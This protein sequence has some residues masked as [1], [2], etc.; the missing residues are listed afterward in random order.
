MRGCCQIYP[1]DWGFLRKLEKRENCANFAS[2]SYA[3]RD[4]A[5]AT[6]VEWQDRAA[7]FYYRVLN[8]LKLVH[9]WIPVEELEVCGLP[10]LEIFRVRFDRVSRVY[11]AALGAGVDFAFITADHD[12]RNSPAAVFTRFKQR[13]RK[14]VYVTACNTGED[15]G[16]LEPTAPRFLV[17]VVGPRRLLAVAAEIAAIEGLGDDDDQYEERLCELCAEQRLITRQLQ[18]HGVYAGQ[19]PSASSLQLFRFRLIREFPAM[20]AQTGTARGHR[21]WVV[22]HRRCGSDG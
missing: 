22:Q 15:V 7:A 8:E 18:R 4:I 20:L 6:K 19:P 5:K 3:A 16:T 11:R 13:P 10:F 9:R 14:W 1:S 21:G 12:C 2:M 17:E